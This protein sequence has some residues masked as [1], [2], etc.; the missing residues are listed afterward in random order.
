MHARTWGHSAWKLG[1]CLI[2]LCLALG[3]ARAASFCPA[4]VGFTAATGDAY[5]NHDIVSWS[6]N[7]TAIDYPDFSSTAG[8]NLVGDA[9]QFGTVLRLTPAA[10][11]KHGAAWFTTPQEVGNGFVTT[12]QFRLTGGN[13]ADGF[14]FVIQKSPD[15]DNALGGFGSDLGYA[16]IPDSVAVEFRPHKHFPNEFPVPYVSV[17][18]RGALPNSSDVT[19]SLGHVSFP[20]M[21]DGAVHSVNIISSP[22]ITQIFL[23]GASSPNLTVPVNLAGELGC[24]AP[25]P[26]LSWPM[27][28]FLFVSL[29]VVT[30]WRLRSARR[31]G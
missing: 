9:A 29:T 12:F 6:F 18:T 30:L 11:Q 13:V 16:G 24:A 26:A 7:G 14:A 4:F 19:F 31:R 10:A 8:L 2:A 23:D 17:Q 1:I 28:A 27:L 3:P 21:A 25:A 5:E 20:S 15:G 22:G